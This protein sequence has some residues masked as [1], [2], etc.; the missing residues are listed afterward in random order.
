MNKPTL[1]T[2][3]FRRHGI[4]YLDIVIAALERNSGLF[5]EN[6]SLESGDTLIERADQYELAAKSGYDRSGAGKAI[7][8]LKRVV[9]L[10][11]EFSMSKTALS[12]ARLHEL[13]TKEK[14]KVVRDSV[15]LSLPGSNE[16]IDRRLVTLREKIKHD[17]AFPS[18]SWLEDKWSGSERLLWHVINE[19]P[20][21][22]Q[23]EWYKK[24]SPVFLAN[25]D[26]VEFV[27][28]AASN[29]ES[30]EEIT[31]SIH[32]W[33]EREGR[34]ERLLV[35]LYGTSTA[36]QFGWYYLAWRMPSLKDS[37]FVDCLDE[38]KYRQARFAP[39]T[40]RVVQKDPISAIGRD[41]IVVGW[42]SG[43]RR[44]AQGLLDFYL[45]QD[46][47]FS[48]LLLGERGSGKSRAVEEAWNRTN[49]GGNLV[50]ANCA[51]FREPTHAQSELFGHV[52]GAFTGAKQEREG[53]LKRAQNGLLFLDEVHHLDYTTRSMLLSALQTDS[54][55]NFRFRKLGGNECEVKFQPVFAS[56]R[57]PEQLSDQEKGLEPDFL[58]RISQRILEWPNISEEEYESAWKIVWKKMD[59]KGTGLEDPINNS[60]F[61]DWLCKQKLPGNFRDFQRI[62]I[63]VADYQR[64]ITGTKKERALVGTCT[65]LVDYL[66][67]N[68]WTWSRGD[69]VKYTLQK[70]MM[71][72]NI[73]ATFVKVPFDP[74]DQDVT[75]KNFLKEC[76]KQFVLTMTEHFGT[77]KAAVDELRKRGSMMSVSTMS[78]WK[79]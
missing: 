59:F 31:K 56:N 36:V 46:D 37:V 62:A 1:V 5:C 63:M 70:D 25:Q 12:E 47:N 69:T 18:L 28:L 78:K 23:M 27:P 17:N 40:I 15:L 49:R 14:W 35:N 21:E 58:D 13:V 16:Q 32:S 34:G 3:W 72:P 8:S 60:K 43:R 22:F 10:I 48:I 68:F 64:A 73:I 30:P 54:K 52:E 41:S 6:W 67:K 33:L 39:V 7:K 74:A 61:V 44:I 77:Q 76:R 29:L 38:K 79:R 11:P 9:M 42:E 4:S 65:T 24:Y 55:G 2:G 51:N 20:F 26:L 57:S 53:L 66:L 45:R 75:E 50:R 19:A 71:E